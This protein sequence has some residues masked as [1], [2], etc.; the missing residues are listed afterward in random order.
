MTNRPT[1]FLRAI[2]AGVIA[3]H[4]RD[5]RTA[6]ASAR[7]RRDERGSD[8]NRLSSTPKRRWKSRVRGRRVLRTR[9]SKPVLRRALRYRAAP[10]TRLRHARGNGRARR[11]K[12]VD[13]GFR[14]PNARDQPGHESTG[15]P[16]CEHRSEFDS[17]PFCRRGHDGNARDR[18]FSLSGADALGDI[19]RACA[20]SSRSPRSAAWPSRRA[21]RSPMRAWATRPPSAR[22]CRLRAK[23]PPRPSLTTKVFLNDRSFCGCSAYDRQCRRRI[24][25]GSL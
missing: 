2:F 6:G 5:R 17:R 3:C 23:A 1:G 18:S 12:R 11:G 13:V 24:F 19:F 10:A 21:R 22:C 4:A 8:T 25:S 9:R 7:R 14:H 15:R 16:A 20:L